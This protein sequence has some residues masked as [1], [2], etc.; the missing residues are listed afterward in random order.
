MAE[1][2]IW[3][4]ITISPLANLPMKNNASSLPFLANIK[5]SSYLTT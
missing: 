4:Q 1:F 5:L 2:D 3:V